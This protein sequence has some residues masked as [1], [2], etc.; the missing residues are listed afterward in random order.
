MPNKEYVKVFP[1]NPEFLPE[2]EDFILE[3]A[4]ENNVDEDK[5][6][7]LALATAE[8]ASNSMIH[9]NKNDPKK[10]V[11]IKVF[12]SEILMKIIFKDEGNGFEPGAVPDPTTPENILKESG[13][14][15][16][17]MKSYL[18]ALYYN[19]T[20]EGTEAILELSLD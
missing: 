5:F 13:R 10:K 7:S 18:S 19:F 17:I 2:I 12:I 1:S 20:P 14:G 4:K 3:I 6:N 9:G 15:I 11:E 16:H 8:A